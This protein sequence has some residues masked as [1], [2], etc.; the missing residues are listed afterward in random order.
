[1]YIVSNLIV[2]F[3][4]VVCGV[5]AENLAIT[6]IFGISPFVASFGG[7][8][9]VWVARFLEPLVSLS[10]LTLW[11]WRNGEDWHTLGL[12][13]PSNWRRFSMQVTLA[14][15]GLLGLVYIF[16]FGVVYPFLQNGCSTGYT[17][18][19]NTVRSFVFYAVRNGA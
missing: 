13:K 14:I 17:R 18:C 11:L 12:R 10:I 8:P 7:Q 15:I 3:V 1:V 5:I 19:A 6:R 9:Q 16:M 2:W 4:A